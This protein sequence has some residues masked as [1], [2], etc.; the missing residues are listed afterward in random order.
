VESGAW[1][2]EMKN[3]TPLSTVYLPLS[4]LGSPSKDFLYTP[5]F[6]F[7]EGPGL[8]QQDLIAHMTLVLIVMSLNFRSFPDI[9]LID[10]LKDQTIDHDDDG[11]IHLIAGNH[12]R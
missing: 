6:L 9:F 11:F 2:V 1:Q 7:A 4:K 8:D 5:T 10:W 12:A 3:E